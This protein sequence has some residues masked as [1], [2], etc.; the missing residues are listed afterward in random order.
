MVGISD[1]DSRP[2]VIG[3]CYCDHCL[4]TR[5]SGRLSRWASYDDLD[6]KDPELRLTPEHFQLFPRSIPG[7][8]LKS[9]TWGEQY[10][11]RM[12]QILHNLT[13]LNT[14]FMDINCASI[15]EPN[16]TAIRNLVMNDSHL[17]LVR[18]LTARY[19]GQGN[20]RNLA[21][22]ADFIRSKGE[23]QIFLLHGPPGVGKTYTAECIAETTRKL[24]RG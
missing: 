5:A 9:R 18:I 1:D 17:K 21:W 7:F 20:G 6:P 14:D 23:G 8:I 10:P 2:G 13:F 19:N 12:Q 24:R 4:V 22:S 15:F 11:R 3:G 16:E